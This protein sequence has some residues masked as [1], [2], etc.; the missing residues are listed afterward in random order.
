M[1]LSKVLNC[2]SIEFD[3][4]ISTQ[5]LERAKKVF[6]EYILKRI[7]KIDI[8]PKNVFYADDSGNDRG[9]LVGLDDCKAFVGGKE[10]PW[11]NYFKDN[12]ISKGELHITTSEQICGVI[13]GLESC[14]FRKES[15]PGCDAGSK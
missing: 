7:L 6:G 10:S 2:Q 4:N 15:V 13:Q 1:I 5:R 8:T 3:A 14:K 12:P 11:V 9:I